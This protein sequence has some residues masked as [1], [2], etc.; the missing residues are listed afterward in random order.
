[1][2]LLITS[3]YEDIVHVY[4]YTLAF[5]TYEDLQDHPLKYFWGRQDAEKKLVKAILTLW[6]DKGGEKSRLL[7]QQ[8]LPISAVVI[9]LVVDG[10]PLEFCQVLV[11][12][13]HWMH[14]PGYIPI[15]CR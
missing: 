12:R 5:Q 15:E 1:M 8:D 9:K 6:C 14:F 11:D 3:M 13:F 2:F 7:I 10:T 4:Y